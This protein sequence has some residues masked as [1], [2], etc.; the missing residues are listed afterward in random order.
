[1]AIIKVNHEEFVVTIKI[2]KRIIQN[3]FSEGVKGKNASGKNI[4]PD[5]IFK[6]DDDY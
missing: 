5:F 3:F 1:M 6:K 4:K 2:L